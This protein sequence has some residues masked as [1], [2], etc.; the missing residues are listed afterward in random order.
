MN[1]KTTGVLLVL[2]IGAGLGLGASYVLLPSGAGQPPA[3]VDPQ[4]KS[5]LESD[6]TDRPARVVVEYGRRRVELKRAAGKTEWTMPGNWETRPDEVRRLTKLLAALESR[7]V[8]VALTDEIR[9]EDGLDKPAVKVTLEAG[10]KK[11]VLEFG[12]PGAGG[13][14]GAESGNSFY[15]PTFLRLDGKDEAI[16]LAP[17]LVDALRQPADYYLQRWLFLPPGKKIRG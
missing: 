12:K 11:Q 2:V 7:F 8:P 5:A 13:G 9:K 16:R 15:H 3:I 4:I 1:P 10:D 17:G 14:E 6:K